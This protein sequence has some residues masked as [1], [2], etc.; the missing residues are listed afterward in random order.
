MTYVYFELLTM[1]EFK[2][3]ARLKSFKYAIAGITYLFKTQ[4]NSWIQAV[5]S[6]FAIALGF[7][8]KIN[9]S[10]W[11]LI[12]F[13]IGLVLSAEAFNTAL[14][15]LTDLVSPQYNEKAKIIKDVSAAGVLLSAL[16]SLSIGLIVFIPKILL[17][18]F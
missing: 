11:C 10:E 4:H 5:L 12:I 3:T 14:E 2:I 13:A 1:N 18:I 15:V 8:L 17:L 16:T 7:I 6:A 9:F